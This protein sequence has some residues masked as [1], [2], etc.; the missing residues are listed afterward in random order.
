MSLFR[1]IVLEEKV[2]ISSKELYA[3]ESF[4]DII[5]KK[6]KERIEGKCNHEGYVR[7]GSIEMIARSA[8]SHEHGRFTGNV[9]FHVQ[10][11]CKVCRPFKGQ[12]LSVKVA[13]INSMGIHGYVE[14]VVGD[15]TKVTYIRVVIPRAL[16]KDHPVYT[17]TKEGDTVSCKILGI[18]FQPYQEYLLCVAEIA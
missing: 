12:S 18:K 4:D 16:Q 8:G 3:H 10:F 6:L 17:S 9:V 13:S 1:D 15:D 2:V 5:V 11:S 14:D 7:H